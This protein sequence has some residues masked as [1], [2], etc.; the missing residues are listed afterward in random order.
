MKVKEKRIKEKTKKLVEMKAWIQE[1]VE[2]EIHVR[3][4]EGTQKRQEEVTNE[5]RRDE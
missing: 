1:G 4:E 3:V 5:G 2:D